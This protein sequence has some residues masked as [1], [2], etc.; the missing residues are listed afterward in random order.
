MKRGGIIIWITFFLPLLASAH[1]GSPNVF[2]EGQAGPYP[3]RVVIR[4]PSVV[5]G[6]AEI[7]VRVSDPGPVQVTALPVYWRAGRKGAP[8]PDVASLVPG[9]TNLYAT[10][11]WFMSSGAYSVDVEVSGTRGKG[12]V[13]V[14]VN[15]VATTRRELPLGLGTILAGLGAFLLFM[16]IWLAGAEHGES[17]VEPGAEIPR[18]L[19]VRSWMAMGLAT[20]LYSSALAGGRYWWNEV[21]RDY[22]TNRLFRPLQISAAVR[23]EGPQRILR[24]V[25]KEPDDPRRGLAPLIADHGKIMHL[26]LIREPGLDVFAH[27]H[28]IQ[29]DQRTFEVALPPLPAGSF[30]IYADVTQETGFA[31]TMVAA[32]AIPEG[33]G[34]AETRMWENSA[35]DPVCASPLALNANTN[36]FLAHDLDDSWH[37]G[38]PE[39]AGKVARSS[40]SGSPAASQIQTCRVANGATLVWESDGTLRENREATLRFK[41][42]SASGSPLRL[43]AYMGMFGHAAVRRTDGAVFAHLHPMGTISMAS[44]QSFERREQAG[45]AAEQREPGRHQT[46]T[47]DT[48]SFPYEFPQAGSYRIWV[49]VKAAGAVY[50]GV[51]DAVCELSSK[52]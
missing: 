12:T 9:E 37:V 10:T 51:F 13:V 30:R 26:F 27:L 14:P 25:A 18:N 44:Q 16:A 23:S 21:D 1:V 35:R 17:M 15:S 46:G 45:R 39:A 33:A 36:L 42:L 43:E 52:L 29:R 47:A 20:V 34:Q 40:P 48:V 6:L 19:R 5:P 31:Q 4:P 24:L 7:N 8:P 49:Q 50:T 2:F 3:V 32:V 11:L 41:L 38:Q 28:P 22:R